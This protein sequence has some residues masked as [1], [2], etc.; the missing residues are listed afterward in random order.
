VLQYD[1]TFTERTTELLFSMDGKT[2]VCL[3]FEVEEATVVVLSY[4]NQKYYQIPKWAHFISLR[5]RADQVA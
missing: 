4:D 3:Q 5:L 1:K 2:D